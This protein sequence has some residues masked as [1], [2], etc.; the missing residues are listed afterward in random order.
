MYTHLVSSGVAIFSVVHFSISV[1]SVFTTLLSHHDAE[2]SQEHQTQIVFSVVIP[3]SATKFA[4]S[5]VSI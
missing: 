2:S 4:R 5:G 3:A 1:Q